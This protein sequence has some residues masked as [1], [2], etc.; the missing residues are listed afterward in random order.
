MTQAYLVD[1]N[2]S[3]FNPG[4]E[5]IITVNTFSCPSRITPKNKQNPPETPS[6]GQ[7]VRKEIRIPSIGSYIRTTE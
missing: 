5:G 6:S 2:L 7:V 3:M 1:N 4:E